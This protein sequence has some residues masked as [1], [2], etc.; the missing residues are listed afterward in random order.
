MNLELR[1]IV[2]EIQGAVGREREKKI[3]TELSKMDSLK[4]TELIFNLEDSLSTEFPD[5]LLRKDN[6]NSVDSI[7]KTIRK[8]QEYE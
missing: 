6:F 1:E 5:T 3:N 8:L 4:L 2:I 7:R